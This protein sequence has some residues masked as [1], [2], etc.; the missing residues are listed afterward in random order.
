MQVPSNPRVFHETL[1]AVC[2]CL[3]VCV[4]IFREQRIMLLKKNKV[5]DREILT[6]REIFL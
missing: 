1:Q 3:C 4:F 5:G 6:P 2:V